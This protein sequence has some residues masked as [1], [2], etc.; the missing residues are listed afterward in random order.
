M[1][2]LD[3]HPQRVPLTDELH[4]RP[5]QPMTAP[6]RAL[7]LAFMQ[8][9]AAVER[10]HSLDRAHLLALLDQFGAPHPPQQIKQYT[11]ILGDLRLKWES[12][13]EFVTYTLIADQSSSPLYDNAILDLLDADW[14]AAAPGQTIAA[15]DFEIS[16]CPTCQA[17][18]A[19]TP[20]FL[21]NFDPESLAASQ[22]L[23][24]NAIALG[25][26]RIDDRGFTR[27]ALVVTGE[28]G[29][30]RIGRA[31]QRIFEIEV[32]RTM[33]SL[34]LPVA[35]TAAQRLNE[36]EHAMTDLM[37]R[38]REPVPKGASDKDLLAELTNLSAEVE[39]LAAACA[40]RM[41][42]AAA[43]GRIVA[44]RISLLKEQPIAGRQ[45]FAEFMTRRFEPAMRTIEAAK[46]RQMALS[47]R[48]ARFAELL[49]TRVNVQL[50]DQNQQVLERMDRR[51]ALH[52]RLQ[53]TVEGLSVV[54]ISYYAVSLLGYFFG[55]A[56]YIPG[57]SKTLVMSVL[58]VPVVLAVWYF[59]HRIRTRLEKND[60]G[61]TP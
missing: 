53:Q 17:S 49:R 28:T 6:G 10:D 60:K 38:A 42:A 22:V 57:L 29:P 9:T 46:S 44:D 39:A 32:Y 13:T 47:T 61:P 24:Q 51:A 8:E 1:I 41:D 30:R 40:F 4:A 23:D 7:L 15:A 3:N 11:A 12:H 20:E 54:A 2:Q 19:L 5:F 25:D 45:Q 18:D 37:D 31:V 21:E 26:F 33:A 52:L 58:I 59:V 56:S 16:S 55:P 43:Y 36:I 14:L 34:A 35:R 27:F 48:V 50:E